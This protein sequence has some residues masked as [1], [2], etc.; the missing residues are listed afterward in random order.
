VN[1]RWWNDNS[2]LE[3][4]LRAARPEA[5]DELVRSLS[6]RA[7]RGRGLRPAPRIAFAGLASAVM[8]VGLA[9]VGGIGRAA[10]EIVHVVRISTGQTNVFGHRMALHVVTFSAANDQYGGGGGGGG[11][12]SGGG[13]GGG[14]GNSGGGGGGGGGGG[15]AG[16]GNPGNNGNNGNNGNQTHGNTTS[17][18]NTPGSVSV[19]APAGAG[20][21]DVTWPAGTFSSTVVVTADSAPP[22][23]TSSA[24][25]GGRSGDNQLVSI[26]ATN[27]SGTVV[28][29]LAKPLDVL[30]SNPPKN[31]VP[32]ISTD[33]V[34]FRAVA[35]I[36]GPDLPAGQQ[37]GY[38]VDAQGNIHILTRHLTIFAVLYSANVDVS[39]SGKKTPQAGSG[40]FGDPTRNHVGAPVL[41]QV[42]QIGTP[43]TVKGARVVPFTFFVDEQAATYVSIFDADGNR[44]TIERNGTKIRGHRYT[45][46]P[47]KT[48]H[49]AILRPGTIRTALRIPSRLLKAGEKYRI[50][51]T[52]ID[53]D[54]HKTINYVEF[55]A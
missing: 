42:G 10:S 45:G 27:A 28:H 40:L 8:L 12:N 13:G 34:N 55:T 18:A 7:R 17:Q 37:D 32:V 54:G 9:A 48:L 44:V 49:L 14:G 5:P 41:E 24:L 33:G 20:S 53:F 11:G 3:A 43:K 50:R 29:E 1:I 51:V 25:I 22:Q 4:R 19:A 15:P 31:F 39:E 23:V 30:F 26:V 21:V 36:T 47:V 16:G 2:K 6:A 38:Y 35:K 46:T 52:A